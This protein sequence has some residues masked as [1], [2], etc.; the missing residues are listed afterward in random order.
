MADG[1]GLENQWTAMSRGFE[2]H[3]LRHRFSLI[4]PYP[5][6]HTGHIVKTVKNKPNGPFPYCYSNVTAY[7]RAI[8]NELLT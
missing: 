2:S 7:S 3:G 1:A 4:I 6:G 5:K 8:V